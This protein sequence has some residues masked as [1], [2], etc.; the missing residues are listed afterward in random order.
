M[1]L[2]GLSHNLTDVPSLLPAPLTPATLTPRERV[3]LAHLAGGS[4]LPVIA[5]EL[6]VSEN[7]VRSQARSVYRKLGVGTRD[8][9]VAE[10][11]KRGITL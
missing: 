3:V 7:T 1:R 4:S 6:F 11:V 10:A 9:A 5:R 2:A 8:E